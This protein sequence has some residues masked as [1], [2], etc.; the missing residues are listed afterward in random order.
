MG[1][2][3]KWLAWYRA[4]REGTRKIFQKKINFFFQK[5]KKKREKGTGMVTP[6]TTIVNESPRTKIGPSS[7]TWLTVG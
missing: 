3:V 5:K 6:K 7:R 1:P 4:E 2:V